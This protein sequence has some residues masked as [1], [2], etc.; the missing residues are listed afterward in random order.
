MNV[1]WKHGILLFYSFI[2]IPLPEIW[3]RKEKVIFDH[4]HQTHI[5]IRETLNR[6]NS[7][8][9]NFRRASE[10]SLEAQN[11]PLW[12]AIS[13]ISLRLPVPEISS[14]EEKVNFWSFTISIATIFLSLIRSHLVSPISNFRQMADV[15]SR[16]T[17]FQEK[18]AGHWIASRFIDLC[19]AFNAMETLN[20]HIF[21]SSIL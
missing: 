14:C 9:T 19:T 18:N 6:Y 13:F 15:I 8:D 17:H 3:S 4:L 1:H 11:S 7:E 16:R 5:K 10:R 20:L 12:N 21:Y 2:S